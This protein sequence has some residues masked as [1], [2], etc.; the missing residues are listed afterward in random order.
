MLNLFHEG[1][2]EP[3]DIIFLAQAKK[4][5]LKGLSKEKDP[6]VSLLFLPI[7]AET[8]CHLIPSMGRKKSK[9]NNKRWGYSFQIKTRIGVGL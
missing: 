5:P 8:K 9:Q 4:P 6:K 1:G 3:E 2:A 7:Q